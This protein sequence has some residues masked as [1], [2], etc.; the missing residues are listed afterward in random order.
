MIWLKPDRI[1]HYNGKSACFITT[2]YIFSA[3]VSVKVMILAFKH[4]A[5]SWPCSSL[6]PVEEAQKIK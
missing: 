4:P 2:R 5:S 1:S 6:V 3:F